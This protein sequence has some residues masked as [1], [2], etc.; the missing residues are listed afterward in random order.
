MRSATPRAGVRGAA[1]ARNA[2][3]Y[4]SRRSADDDTGRRLAFCKRGGRGNARGVDSGCD[5]KPSE[6]GRRRR[7]RGGGD[8]ELAVGYR[9]ESIA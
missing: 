8:C 2:R 3:V 9:A 5:T 4:D 1:V 7:R 6:Q